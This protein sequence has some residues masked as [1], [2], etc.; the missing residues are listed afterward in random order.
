M[1]TVP[2]VVLFVPSC[3]GTRKLTRHLKMININQQYKEHLILDLVPPLDISVS[4]PMQGE[5]QSYKK[6]YHGLI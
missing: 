3:R 2:S 5:L 6:K 4:I 1:K